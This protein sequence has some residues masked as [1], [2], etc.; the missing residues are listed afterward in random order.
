MN[1]KKFLR[2]LFLFLFIWV[3][4][5]NS[6]YPEK[7][8]SKSSLTELIIEGLKWRNI[9]PANMGG[10][11]DDFAVIE[12][13]PYIFYVATASGGVWKTINNGITWEPVFDEQPVSSIGAIAVA[14]SDPNIV[15]VGT[16]EANNRQS[17]SWGNGVYKSTDGGKTWKHMG[18]TETHHIGRIVIHPK[19]PNIVYV[20]G[21]GHLWGP[22]KERG[23]F[24]TTDGGKT[25]EKVLYINEDT[26]CIDVAIDPES[27][28]TLYAAMY[29]RRRTPFGFNGGGPY[30]GLYKTTDGGKT[31]IKLTNGLPKGDTGRIGIAIYRKNPD[32]VYAI[33]E[34][35]DGG[36]F[37][38]EDRGLTWKKM[39]STNP[40]PMYYSQIRIDPNNDLRIWVLGARMYYSEDG[41]KTFRTDWVTRIHGDHHALWIN[42]KNSNHMILG[43][44]GG[45]HI[46]YDG[47]KTWDFINN[48][49]LGQF[50][51]VGYDMRKPYYVYGGLQDN[52]T[53]AGPSSTKYAVGITNED[54]YKVGGG[55]GFYAQVDPIDHNI[56]YIESQNGNLM[57]FNLKTGQRRAIRPIPKKE[58]EEYRFNW[59]SPLLISPHDSKT[60]YYG[61]NK[62]FISH[63]RGETWE[64]TIDLTKQI[65]RDKLKIMGVP[66]SDENILSKNDGIS[67]YGNITTISESPIR[68]GLIWVGTDD[69]NLQVSLDGGKTWENVVN[70]IKGVPEYTP[71]TRVIASRFRE[72][73]A[74]VTFDGHTRD[75]FTPY[76]FVTEDY[77]KTWK[78]LRSNLPDGVTI[79]VIREHH[80]NPNLLFIG[81][82]FGAYFTIDR[83]KKWVKFKNLPTVPVDDIA[84]HPRE[85]DLIFGTHGRSVWIL[86]D[87]T[88]LEQ[89][90]QAV[91][92]SDFYL[93]DIRPT[94]I[95]SYISHKG[96][97][98]H[99]FFTAPNPPFGAIINYYLKE[100][101]KEKVKIII[102]DSKG[103]KIRE[104]S[105]PSKQGINRI[106]WD[107]RYE[108]PKVE[109][110]ERRGFFGVP[111]APFVLPDTYQ[112]KLVVGEKEMNKTVKI[113][114]DS[115]YEISFEEYKTWHDDLL[116]LM[117][118]FEKISKTSQKIEK[119]ETRLNDIEKKL[120]EIEGTD[121]LINKVND[122]KEKISEIKNSLIGGKDYRS[123]RRSV[124]GRIMMLYYSISSYIAPPTP[125]QKQEIDRISK[126][127]KELI[128]RFNT[129]IETEILKL[130]QL[131]KEKN[132][133]YI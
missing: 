97:L 23:L 16:G 106:N 132:I 78:S 79:N 37:R 96:N 7:T 43:S 35:K 40:R 26:G 2:V 126:K 24:K 95:F 64:E 98:G 21:A 69:G 11:I 113:E 118:I 1:S 84:I 89:L 121:E 83:G 105:G 28:D 17:S 49:P 59:N 45:I 13:K 53:W 104:L 39:S 77:G 101:L 30:S 47:G 109:R 80:R 68:K 75:D 122:F 100:K 131:L 9:G 48:I 110:R 25:W 108:S 85:N 20:A 93:F 3:I 107:L 117:G 103:K 88:P 72:G 38:S 33:I 15:W 70:R 58:G 125:P 18:L 54:W 6:A 99:K 5:F 22:N 76:V 130:N 19:N 91:L 71:V 61:G 123:R 52:G 55:D 92:D 82:E 63:D 112:V 133:S 116:K 124:R 12:D 32:I 67:S 94:T 62:L 10:R 86:D 31:W 74:Y 114:L 90:T 81:T 119:I 42:P 111:R 46:S 120:K 66:L 73:R 34:N 128:E 29:Q 87:I 27:P 127:S 56:V 50:Y 41:G 4:G 65:D 36:V 129:L 44:D 57:R 51:E 102:F 14:P 8:I 60:I 115:M